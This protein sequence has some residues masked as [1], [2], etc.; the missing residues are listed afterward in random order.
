RAVR[1]RGGRYLARHREADPHRDRARRGRSR[2][3]RTARGPGD[4]TPL[5]LV[6]EPRRD[7]ARTPLP[8]RAVPAAERTVS[9]GRIAISGIVAVILISAAA[10]CGYLA[11]RNDDAPATTGDT[12]R[13][14]T[15]LWSPRRV[16]QPLVDAVG[17][18]R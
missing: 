11:L 13:L 7:R 8:V 1:A 5:L 15:P 17:A 9:G 16:P 6:L 2:Q 4:R 10:G 14:A 18:Q 3:P 12:P